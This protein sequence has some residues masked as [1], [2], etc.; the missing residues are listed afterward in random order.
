MAG[1]LQ[2]RPRHRSASCT[3]KIECLATKRLPGKFP[4]TQRIELFHRILPSSR[5]YILNTEKE[6]F[7]PQKEVSN[8][9]RT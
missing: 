9:E 7:Q 3:I 4:A 2:K 1:P 5:A 6:A 8:H